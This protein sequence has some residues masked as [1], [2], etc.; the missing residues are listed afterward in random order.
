MCPQHELSI[1]F[2]VGQGPGRG[3]F[4]GC[5]I[6]LLVAGVHSEEPLSRGVK[7]MS[8]FLLPCLPQNPWMDTEETAFFPDMVGRHWVL[9]RL[10]SLV[11]NVEGPQRIQDGAHREY[12]FWGS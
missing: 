5:S 2:T 1:V 4:Y 9:L 3:D 11:P 7:G 10:H 6:F 12:S 8:G